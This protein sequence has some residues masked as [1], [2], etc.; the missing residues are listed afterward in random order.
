METMGLYKNQINPAAGQIHIALMGDPTLRLHVVAPPT[1]LS[2][3]STG[4]A[5]KLSWTA[6]TGSGFGIP[7]LSCEQRK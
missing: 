2:A 6:S 4:N 7:R 5:V 3:S 1:Q